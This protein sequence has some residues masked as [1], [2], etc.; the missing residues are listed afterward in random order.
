MSNINRRFISAC[1][2]GLVGVSLAAAQTADVINL[3]KVT[4]RDPIKSTYFQGSVLPVVEN[5]T[6]NFAHYK[7]MPHA[8]TQWHIHE[9][10]Q[11][12]L[13]EEGICRHQIKGGPIIE[14][15]AGETAYVPPGAAHWQGSTPT[16][17]GTQFN[18]HRGKITWLNDV[19]DEEYNGPVAPRK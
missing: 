10:G 3:T 14:F 4:F 2:V 15:R 18:I 8:R 7:F 6:G 12:L 11:I 13:C 9:G 5:S 16:T 19:T 17:A 1:A